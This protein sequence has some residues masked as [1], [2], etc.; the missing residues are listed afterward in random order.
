MQRGGS[1]EFGSGGLGAAG[2]TT[3]TEGS[4]GSSAQSR[5]LLATLRYGSANFLL[6][7]G[8]AAL[9]IGGWAIWVVLALALVFGSFADEVSGDDD[10][11]LNESQC[12]FCT[13]NLYLTLPLVGLLAFLLVRFAALRPSLAE[14]PLEAIGA[15]WLTGY[16]FA[17]AG[18]TVAH[19]LTHRSN[20]LA[21]LSAYLLLGFTGNTSFVIYHI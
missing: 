15:L 11:S 20:R 12:I 21:K 8:A 18:A 3:A 16:L 5:S 19:E 7:L 6:V 2:T 14:Q 1:N 10:T 13:L 9:L 17:L 4:G